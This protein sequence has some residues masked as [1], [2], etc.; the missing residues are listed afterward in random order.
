MTGRTCRTFGRS[1]RV[2]TLDRLPQTLWPEIA[3]WLRATSASIDESALNSA[4]VLSV[5]WTRGMTPTTTLVIQGQWR[6]TLS[7]SATALRQLFEILSLSQGHFAIPVPLGQDV[8][9]VA[10]YKTV[11]PGDG[12]GVEGCLMHVSVHLLVGTETPAN[13]VTLERLAVTL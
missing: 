1:S 8:A 2:V 13:A 10:H 4:S 7:A 12:G 3:P 5:S 11:R 6:S 9:A